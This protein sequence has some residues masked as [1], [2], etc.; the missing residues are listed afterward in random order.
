MHGQPSVL[1]ARQSC[2]TACSWGLRLQLKIDCRYH[3]QRLK[4]AKKSPEAITAL[5]PQSSHF[6]AVSRYRRA[7]RNRYRAPFR[8]PPPSE[9]SSI[10]NSHAD[11]ENHQYAFVKAHIYHGTA[12]LVMSLMLIAVSINSMSVSYGSRST[13]SPLEVITGS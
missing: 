2:P 3:L 9:Y 8:R 13:N 12:D 10:A 7:E 1:L 5:T 4:A 11:H 6:G